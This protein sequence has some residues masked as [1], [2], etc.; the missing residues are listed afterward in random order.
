MDHQLFQAIRM[1]AAERHLRAVLDRHD[2]SS[3]LPLLNQVLS[4]LSPFL[5]KWAGSYLVGVKPAGSC[6]KGTAILGQTDLDIF[7][8]LRSDLDM[9]L[10]DISISLRAYLESAGLSPRQQDVSF[11]INYRAVAIDVTVGRQHPSIPAYHS[12]YRSKADTWTQTN[13]DVHIDAVKRSGL[14]DEIRLLKIWRQQ[15]SLDFP[16]FLLELAVIDALKANR[17]GS[18]TANLGTVFR[19]LA[20]EFRAR[21]LVDPSNSNNVVSDTMTQPEKAKILL[22][23]VAAVR[24]SSWSDVVR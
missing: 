1:G 18:L 24:S 21:R 4:E 10:R 20:L 19:Y 22:A 13:I 23:A 16:S 9:K 7:I 12:I 14:Q 5:G 8:S 15:K 11:G 3:R 17:S 2:L 6:I